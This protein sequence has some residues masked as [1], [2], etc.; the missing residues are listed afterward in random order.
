MI[1]HDHALAKRL[2]TETRRHRAPRPFWQRIPW[3]SEAKIDVLRPLP[4]PAVVCLVLMIGGDA[5]FLSHAAW[6]WTA[7]IT[8]SLA[9]GFQ[10]ALREPWTMLMATVMPVDSRELHRWQVTE[11]ARRAAWVMWD[12]LWIFAAEASWPEL[13]HVVGG[14]LVQALAAGAIATGFVVLLPWVRWKVVSLLPVGAGIFLLF[15]SSRNDRLESWFKEEFWQVMSYSPA[16]ILSQWMEG[17]GAGWPG[18]AGVGFLAAMGIAGS[19]GVSGRRFSIPVWEYPELEESSEDPDLVT[20][21]KGGILTD[22]QNPLAGLR[23]WD[24]SAFAARGWLERCFHAWMKPGLRKQLDFAM[25]SGWSWSQRWLAGAACAAAAVGFSLTKWEGL[26]IMFTAFAYGFVVPL[27][28][29]AW[30]GLWSARVGTSAATY[31]S[32]LPLPLPRLAWSVVSANS[33]QVLVGAPVLFAAAW[34]VTGGEQVESLGVLG[35]V[36]GLSLQMFAVLFKISS[37]TRPL[38]YRWWKRPWRV[39]QACAGVVLVIAAGLLWMKGEG[40]GIRVSGLLLIPAFAAFLLRRCLARISKGRV[41]PTGD[42][43]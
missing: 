10:E 7:V 31:A 37:S 17:A 27:Q 15:I 2:K 3:R 11:W 6:L 34:A 24:G 19:L 18:V 39:I 41:D 28:G 33:F 35:F 4:M 43:Y 25:A 23:P 26:T 21:S 8:L 16:A 42:P 9:A 14:A 13:P 12:W 38:I 30:V 32:M 1:R 22:S 36:I 29:G 20:G 5:P 40:A